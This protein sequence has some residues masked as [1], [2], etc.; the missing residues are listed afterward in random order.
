MSIAD[1]TDSQIIYIGNLIKFPSQII[2]LGDG[3]NYKQE[4]D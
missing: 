2:S 3:A 4:E 1:G